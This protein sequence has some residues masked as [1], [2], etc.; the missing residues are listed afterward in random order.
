[1]KLQVLQRSASK[2]PKKLYSG[3]VRSKALHSQ[4]NDTNNDIT[5]PKEKYL[6]PEKRQQIIDELRLV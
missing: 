5:V 3:E 4:N 1:M 2:S 6:S